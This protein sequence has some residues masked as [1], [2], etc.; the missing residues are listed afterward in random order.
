MQRW[1]NELAETQ[2]NDPIKFGILFDI[3]QS[4]VQYWKT[5]LNCHNNQQN[6]PIRQATQFHTIQSKVYYSLFQTI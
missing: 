2:Q 6:Y 1:V 4:K 5:K 3:L